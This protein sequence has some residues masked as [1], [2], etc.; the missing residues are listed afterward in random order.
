M[1]ILK[2]TLLLTVAVVA[3]VADLLEPGGFRAM[4]YIFSAEDAAGRA[5]KLGG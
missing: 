3:V 4:V 5:F 1:R 2:W